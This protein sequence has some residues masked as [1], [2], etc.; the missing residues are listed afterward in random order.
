MTK[1]ELLE[2]IANTR[3]DEPLPYGLWCAVRNALGKPYVSLV[4]Y[5][6]ERDA[7]GCVTA[8]IVGDR[9]VPTQKHAPSGDR[10]VVPSPPDHAF[11]PIDSENE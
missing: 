10:E 11:T 4:G 7:D 9:R 8:I 3:P 2:A 5:P 6:F 1:D